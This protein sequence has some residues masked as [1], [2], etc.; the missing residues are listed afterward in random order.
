MKKYEFNSIKYELIKDDAQ[1]LGTNDIS[2]LITDYF[3]DFD[4]IFGD[5][6]YNKIRLK[7]FCDKK[8]KKFN[9][10]NDISTLDSYIENYCAFN[11]KW[12]LLKKCNN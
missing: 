2:S 12:F 3:K 10:I 8:N 11:C 9:K 1:I 5:I 6:A 7:G 4:Y